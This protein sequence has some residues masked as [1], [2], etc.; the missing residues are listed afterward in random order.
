MR[1]EDFVT[2]KVTKAVA[3]ISCGLRDYLTLG[4]LE[5]KRDWGH[6]R[7]YVQGMWMMLQQDKPDDY[8]L[9]TGQVH[10]V[11]Q[12]VECAFAEIDVRLVWCGE[13]EN[14]Q[15][16]DRKTGK[17]LV[18]IDPQLYRPN[19]VHHLC[20]DYSKALKNLGWKPQTSFTCMIG[21]MVQA[22]I[23]RLR[24]KGEEES[25]ITLFKYAA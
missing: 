12:L 14:E 22:D 25:E 11:R 18:K 20:G 23:E 7:D 8:V 6:A 16:I 19:E 1:G 13:A 10:S 5:A 9:A 21:D 17:V 4:N 3:E 15:A 24:A 2:R